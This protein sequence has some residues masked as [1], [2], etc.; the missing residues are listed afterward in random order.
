[1]SISPLEAHPVHQ[2]SASGQSWLL[3]GSLYAAVIAGAVLMA[4]AEMSLTW[5]VVAILGCIAHGIV[6]GPQ[7][8]PVLSHKGCQ[9]WSVGA[10]LF[11]LMQTV[12]FSVHISYSLVH[13]FILVQLVL[14]FGP[15]ERRQVRLVQVLVIAELM[16]AGIWALDL[17]Y[18]PAFLFA[19]LAVI[20][21][22]AATQLEAGAA[23]R[24]PWEGHAARKRL[25]GI[26]TL[27]QAI[28]P[29]SLLVFGAMVVLFILMPRL[30]VPYRIKA[31][32][33]NWVTGF[34]QD[35]SLREVGMLRESFRVAMEVR[36]FRVDMAGEPPWEPP[37]VL[38]RGVSLPAYRHGQWFSYDRVRGITTHQRDT[39]DV[40]EEITSAATYYRFG[41]N[42]VST[43]RLLQK[44]RLVDRPGSN[45]FALY[46]WSEIR[47]YEGTP[48]HVALN[49]LSH[50]LRNPFS[51][52]TR[53]YQVTSVV[54]QFSEDQLRSTDCPDEA[55]SLAFFWHVPDE[56]RHALRVT[57]QEIER[58]YDPQSDYDRIQAAI[59]YLQDPERFSYSFRLP[60]FGDR[61]PVVAFL[62]ET[63]RGSCE[64][65]ASALAMIVRMWD[66]PSRLVAGYKGGTLDP[67]TFN[68]VF[69][70][71]DAHAWVEVYFG[72]LG[73][74]EFDPT[75]AADMTT[76]AA[77][78]V[79]G[80]MNV[81][82]RAWRAVQSAFRW[83]DLRWETHVV[84]YTRTHQREALSSLVALLRSAA[85]DATD[86]F[87][88]LWPNIPDLGLIHFALA[89]VGFTFVAMVL[90]GLGAWAER[91]I[92]RLRQRERSHAEVRFYEDMLRLLSRK[93]L[94]RPPHLTP[95][96]FAAVA[97]ERL[98]S[99]PDADE[100]SVRS[101]L[102]AVTDYYYITRCGGRS[103]PDEQ[104]RS[105]QTALRMLKRARRVKR[106]LEQSGG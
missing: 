98:L 14:L 82:A 50:D 93:G 99:P 69:R 25:F 68:Y 26:K 29:I 62:T 97:S 1:M 52:G 8:R 23:G 40:A 37:Q 58:L 73:W 96:E 80:G 36:F 45:L 48:R 61:D 17:I 78:G 64:Q 83:I 51:Y 55:P 21:T 22:M 54:P 85:D 95:R 86:F 2:H 46:R 18:L 38:M 47:D 34:S 11:A 67:Q 13:F 44:I 53:E 59:D 77:A 105:I 27:L 33:G 35:V 90:Y 9:L 39:T 75:P 6:S 16:V 24:G 10:L 71:R 12:V 101:A 81:F 104:R 76:G 87:Q 72:E 57:I 92:A 32:V 7:A 41:G 79:G 70:G 49:P 91:A 65:F 103:P 42:P 4:A 20:V 94:R 60:D 56:L 84:G 63:R 19:G 66:M 102:Q 15:R 100:E 88:R 30:I 106:G 43:S 31:H 28:W 74:V 5:A 3:L 89:V